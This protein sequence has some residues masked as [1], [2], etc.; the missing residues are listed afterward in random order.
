MSTAIWRTFNAFGVIWYIQTDIYRELCQYIYDSVC[1]ALVESA[2]G[3]S[4]LNL[5]KWFVWL[6]TH[7]IGGRE[8]Y[9]VYTKGWQKGLSVCNKWLLIVCMCV[10]VLLHC[11]CNCA[12]RHDAKRKSTT[13]SI[14]FPET[15]HNSC[16]SH[17]D[18]DSDSDFDAPSDS[19]DNTRRA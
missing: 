2:A 14:S 16:N 9:R 5:T 13:I 3:K 19:P 15:N 6:H 8:W 17:S 11:A 12:L 1:I 4:P 10:C 18:A 7:F